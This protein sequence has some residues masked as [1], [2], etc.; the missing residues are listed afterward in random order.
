MK[1][2]AKCPYSAVCLSLGQSAWSSLDGL[3]YRQSYIWNRGQCA[4]TANNYERAI[5]KIP[6]ECLDGKGYAVWHGRR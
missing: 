4:M 5:S 1:P 2:C 3:L 6:Q